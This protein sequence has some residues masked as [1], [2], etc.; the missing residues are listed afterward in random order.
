MK[1]RIIFVWFEA[2]F[3]LKVKTGKTVLYQV[4]LV[5]NWELLTRQWRCKMG[6]FLDFYLGLPLGAKF[7]GVATWDP[8]LERIR[9]WLAMWRRRYLSK[10]GLLVLIKSVLHN[11]PVY[12]LSCRLISVTV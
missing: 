5:D 10:G 4:N 3:G 7:R 8:L 12:L 1:V 9:S 2:C 11:L 6:A